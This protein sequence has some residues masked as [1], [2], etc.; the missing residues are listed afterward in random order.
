M[1]TKRTGIK[2]K[3]KKLVLH[4]LSGKC[5]RLTNTKNSNCPW[6]VMLKMMGDGYGLYCYIGIFVMF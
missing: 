1:K 2:L 5:L 3:M 6:A 4:K